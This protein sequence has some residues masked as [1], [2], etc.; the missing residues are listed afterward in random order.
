MTLGEVWAALRNSWWAPVLGLLACAAAALAVS[1]VQAPLYSSST[2]LFVSTPG[3][4]SPT[5]VYQGS[6]FSQQ[7]VTSYVELLRGEELA[8]RV[9]D[10]LGLTMSPKELTDELVVAAPT[11]S[12]LLD[13]T[14]HDRSPQQAQRIAQAM[15]T[16]FA[17]MAAQLEAPGS[18]GDSPV[19]VSV[20]QQPGLPSSPSFPDFPRRVGFGALI[21]LVLGAS[22][23]I[24]RARLDRSV[25]DPEQVADLIGVPVVG[26]I[27][28]DDALARNHTVDLTRGGRT[29][30][31]YR[32][33]RAGLEVLDVQEPPKVIL[34]S[35]VLPEEGATTLVANLGL[36]LAEAGKRV[37][38]VEADLRR[39][40]LTRYLGMAAG[41]GL[42]NVLLE[43]ATLGEVAH[44]YREDLT[45][46]AG[47]PKPPNLGHLLASSRM[48]AVVEKLRADNDVVLIQGPPL[49]PMADSSSLAA[50]CDAVLLSVRY[51]KTQKDQLRQAVTTLERAGTRTIGIVLNLVPPTA[52]RAGAGAG[53]YEHR[54]HG[55]G[56]KHGAS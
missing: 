37:T 40:K 53:D 11:D 48:R 13:V 33:L 47:G 10:R 12:V 34:V 16:E 21:G 26:T 32:Q 3:A 20:I 4:I 27:V 19:K 9:V 1:L 8:R 24:A 36:A 41:P 15:G 14:V 44:P 17:A 46:V 42:T 5:D 29:V 43:R 54:R 18:G 52:D 23:A 45:I 25:K 6:Q 30:E 56:A 31:D 49:L 7:R 28:R 22:V 38:I 50:H 35:S 2:Q 39:A 55:A 51:G